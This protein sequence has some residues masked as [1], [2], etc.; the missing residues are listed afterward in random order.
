MS[1]LAASPAI[2][3]DVISGT[4]VAIEREKGV[5]FLRVADQ[6]GMVKADSKVKVD[7]TPKEITVRIPPERLSKGIVIGKK[8]QVWGDYAT[9]KTA[10]FRAQH[11]RGKHFQG[12]RADPTGVRSRLGK[13]KESFKN[14][15][16]F[17]NRMPGRGPRRRR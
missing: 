11:I 4:V 17:R 12:V 16:R 5:L 8:V 13:S 1:N 15:R 9:S 3:M 7:K 2:S 10:I 14:N 6:P